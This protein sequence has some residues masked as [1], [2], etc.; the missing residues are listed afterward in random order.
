MIAA[1]TPIA[2]ALLPGDVQPR[3][4]CIEQRDA[5][6]DA[7]LMTLAVDRQRDRD[8]AGSDRSGPLGVSVANAC[9]DGCGDGTDPHGLEEVPAGNVFLVFHRA[10]IRL[11]PS[12]CASRRHGDSRLNLRP[13]TNEVRNEFRR[14]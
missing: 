13:E 9:D 5:W 2:D 12:M 1:G 3:A 10:R 6:L 4:H 8:L 14:A 11:I 7:Q